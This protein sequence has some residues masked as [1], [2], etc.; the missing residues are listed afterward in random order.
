MGGE[1][2]NGGASWFPKRLAQ[3]HVTLQPAWQSWRSTQH[4]HERQTQPTLR[5]V[6]A[7]NS[8]SKAQLSL[9]DVLSLTAPAL[10]CLAFPAVDGPKCDKL[11]LPLC[12]YHVP[13]PD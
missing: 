3:K 13:V 2:G 9:F 6:A 8:T 5:V 7:S 1:T 12:R 10:L 11:R 4:R